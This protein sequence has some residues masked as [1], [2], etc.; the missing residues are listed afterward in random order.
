[1]FLKKIVRYH[2][3]KAFAILEP[4]IF[5][6][7]VLLLKDGDT[8][9]GLIYHP[10]VRGECPSIEMCKFNRKTSAWESIDENGY[11][12][13]V[14]RPKVFEKQLFGDDFKF[15]RNIT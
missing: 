12:N 14:A 6:N 15:D 3:G 8:N 4:G 13:I 7:A 5:I 11:I 2:V 9:V 1:M 10:Y